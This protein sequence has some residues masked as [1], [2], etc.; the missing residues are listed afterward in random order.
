VTE[1]P[2]PHTREHPHGLLPGPHGN[3]PDAGGE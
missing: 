3:R 1:E 2:G